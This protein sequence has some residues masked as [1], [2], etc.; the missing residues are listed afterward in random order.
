MMDDTGVVDRS[1]NEAGDRELGL[2]AALSAP[3]L[4]HWVD[5]MGRALGAAWRLTG[6]E[7]DALAA[8]MEEA[9][10]VTLRD[11]GEATAE[12]LQTQLQLPRPLA[13]RMQVYFAG[14]KAQQEAQEGA[15]A[16]ARVASG[17][18]SQAPIGTPQPAGPGSACAP[19][20]SRQFC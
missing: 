9:G 11:L 4:R 7:D 18:A 12:D 13:R 17:S 6:D 20:E 10:Y 5:C 15:R 2:D 14:E 16:A 8:R 19:L 1:G 3:E